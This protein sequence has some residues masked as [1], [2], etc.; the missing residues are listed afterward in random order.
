MCYHIYCIR[1]SQRSAGNSY[2]YSS[3][4]LSL[5]T[6]PSAFSTPDVFLGHILPN[7]VRA[8]I[9][10]VLSE[11]RTRRQSP[12]EHQSLRYL[13][14]RRRRLHNGIQVRNKRVGGWKTIYGRET[15]ERKARTDP[16]TKGRRA[17]LIMTKPLEDNLHYIS[18]EKGYLSEERAAGNASEY[19]PVLLGARRKDRA[20]ASLCRQSSALPMK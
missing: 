9:C 11:T 8:V 2:Y 19:I 12:P 10:H 15:Q 13:N 1:P 14:N 4:D 6:S 18:G 7:G 16:A 5:S 17:A 3:F 20:L